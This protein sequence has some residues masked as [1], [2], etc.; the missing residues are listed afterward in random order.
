MAKNTLP[1]KKKAPKKTQGKSPAAKSRY[2]PQAFPNHPLPSWLSRKLITLSQKFRSVHVSEKFVEGISG[3]LILLAAQMFLD[4]MID[5]NFVVRIVILVGDIALLIFFIRK[6]VLAII[7]PPGLIA[8]ALMAE[9]HWPELKGKVI[10]TVQFSLPRFAEG[11]KNLIEAL[12]KETQKQ[13]APLNFAKIIST[14]GLK[15]RILFALLVALLWGGAFAVTWPSSLAL[16]ERVFLIPAKL[17]R[18]TEVICLSGNKTVPAGDSVLLEAQARGVIPAHGRVTL[19]YKSGRIQEI[20]MDPEKDHR[21][22]FSIK[23][24]RLEEALTYVIRLNDGISDSYQV[25]PLPRPNIKS[26]DCDQ[27][28][29]AYTGLATTKRSVGNLALLSGSRLQI[30]ALANSKI[31]RATMKLIGLNQEQPLTISASDGMTLTGE[32]NIPSSGLTGFSIQLTNEANITSGDETQYRIDLIPDRPP[33]IQIT[34]PERLEELCTLKA[35]PIIEFTANDD[36]GLAK[37]YLCYRVVQEQNLENGEAAVSSLTKKVELDLGQGHPQ[38]VAR[39]YEDWN[40]TTMTPPVIEGT[41]LEYWLEAEDAN[42]VTGPGKGSSEHHIL[43]VVSPMEKKAEIM[44]RMLNGLSEVNTISGDQVKINKDLQ[45]IIQ[46]KP[47]SK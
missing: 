2:A 42:N 28:Y 43:K 38:S 23:V 17:P 13:V 1:Q 25:T 45:N 33:T 24:D 44:D 29:P 32:I 4:W 31:K 27:I 34:K 39:R 22:R 18:K 19:Q 8:C 11:S 12:E 46:A 37:I 36:Y 9:K 41:N 47:A 3:V 14:R 40:L 16:L 7:Q 20:T 35:K 6:R 21:D 5:L 10:A 30:H 15:R 26:I